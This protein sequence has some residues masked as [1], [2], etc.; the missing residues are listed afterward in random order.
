MNSLASRF[1]VLAA[2]SV[3]SFG[4]GERKAREG[5]EEV[6]AP[7]LVI[8][9]LVQQNTEFAAELYGKL[10][11][12]EGNLFMSPYSISS[13]LAM[14]YGGA[15]GETAQEMAKALHFSPDQAH[16]HAT[17]AAL[18]DQ[19]HQKPA[20]KQ[21]YEIHVAN[22]LWGQKSVEF[23]P[24][25][26]DL[27][28]QNYHARLR[29]L[30]FA[31]SEQARQTI[32]G[33]VEERTHNKIKELIGRGLLDAGTKLVLTNAI[34]FKGEW[35]RAFNKD[36]TNTAIFHLS[37]NKSI[38]VRVMHK[39]GSFR[40]L[41]GNGV[42]VLELPY[43]GNKLSLMVFL[44]KKIDGL[45]EFE[46]K[47]TAT[48]LAEWT[49]K[50]KPTDV[51]VHL[52]KFEMTSEF[53]LKGTLAALGMRRA[54]EAPADFSAMTVSK[55]SLSISAVIHKAFVDVNELG[56]EAAAA[57]AILMPPPGPGGGGGGTKYVE[58]RADHPFLF[59]VRHDATGSILFMGR[60]SNPPATAVP[61]PVLP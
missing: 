26:L 53:E 15:R 5:H 12:K 55:E 37:Q 18:V 27:T 39:E 34:Y 33:W 30:D 52:P 16:F 56:T 61:D 4:C 46:T 24:D 48:W 13:A 31:E 7:H 21:T 45:A 35:D 58:F 29:Q 50:L 14:T 40:Y 42:Q 23:S 32:N 43:S 44:P 59:L 41:D 57:T 22:A 54:F 9:D 51:A 19:L 28:D 47:L 60:L 2:L 38:P 17:M 6:V 25:Y 1:L 49:G 3:S 20:T 10:R 11:E 36:R 8:A